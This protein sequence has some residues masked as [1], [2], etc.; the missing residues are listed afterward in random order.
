MGAF[1]WL[2][3][4]FLV[5]MGGVAQEAGP[6]RVR[7]DHSYPPF[8]FVDAD[9]Q[10]AGFNTDILR[11]V[12]RAMSLNFQIDLGPWNEV[13]DQ[14][15]RG[16]IDALAGM[17]RTEE[18]DKLV[19][20]TVPHLVNSYAVFVRDGSGIHSLDDC[21]GRA[22]L[23]QES[24]IAHDYLIEHGIT[25]SI[26]T[27]RES[28]EVLQDLARG[29]G[30]CALVSRLQGVRYIQEQG[31][32][33]IRS[34]GPPVIQRKYCMAVREG[35]AALLAE[36]NEGLAIIKST[37][38]FDRIYEQWFGPVRTESLAFLDALRYVAWILLVMA[39]LI[40]IGFTWSWIL[41]AEVTAKTAVIR[42]ELQERRRTER[43]LGE[44]EAR[45]RTIFESSPLGIAITRSSDEVCVDVNQAML[46]LTGYARDEL[47]GSTNAE[48]KIVS[49]MDESASGAAGEPVPTPTVMVKTKQGATRYALSASTPTVINGEDSAIYMFVDVTER[50]R[51]EEQLRHAQK[52]EAVGQL[53]G[54]VAHDLNNLLQAILGY[55][56]L[57]MDDLEPQNRAVESIGEVMHAGPVSYTHLTLPTN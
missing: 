55:S 30:D 42:E 15:E 4:C 39:A 7:G 46:A 47:I 45:F 57:A 19:D 28:T 56:Q 25:D 1:S 49:Y 43:A 8:E 17:Y 40:A 54:G 37:G 41:R 29:E 44:S 31:I 2:V 21:G 52:M 11:A 48:L 22:I 14:L 5:M 50:H 35:D 26:L 36:L 16:E 3:P 6:I 13:R 33:G 12:G 51:L 38:E 53:A 27:R 24:D 20:F 18:R 32:T 23:V 34:V 9:G 10:P